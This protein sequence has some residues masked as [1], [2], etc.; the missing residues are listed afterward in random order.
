MNNSKSMFSSFATISFALLF[1]AG[2][3]SVTDANIGQP[4]SD[5]SA[6]QA[7]EAS[8][9]T[10]NNENGDDMDTIIVRPTIGQ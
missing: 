8:S 1:A 5:D 6:I 9:D 4:E 3:A 7:I 2:C 10:W